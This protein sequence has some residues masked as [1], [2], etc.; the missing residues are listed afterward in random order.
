ML[1]DPTVTAAK[2]TYHES[3]SKLIV[4]SGTG[5]TNV[6][7]TKVTL[8]PT[9]PGVYK[10]LGVSDDAIRLLL[11]P[12]KDWLPSYLSLKDEG[13]STK[14]ILQV[15]SIDT[16]AGGIT[17]NEPIGVGLIVTD[18]EGVIC[19]DSCEFAFDGVCDD[20]SEPN[21][22]YYYKDVDGDE[23]LC[24]GA[25]YVDYYIGN[26]NY[27]VSALVEGTDCIDCG[28]LDTIVDNTKPL[29]H[30]SGLSSCSNTCIY[31]PQRNKVLRAR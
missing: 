29:D 6:D 27:E 24:G 20:G 26:E 18:R 8:R 2:V 7:N 15:S 1:A 17:F 31:M 12:D 10:V 13:E 14:V 4:I 19:D 23:E 5:F 21:G 22:Q 9:S 25:N 30:E 3:Q 11:K 16:G 28:G